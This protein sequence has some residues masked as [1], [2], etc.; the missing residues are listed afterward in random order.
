M[1]LSAN[2][3]KERSPNIYVADTLDEI[4]EILNPRLGDL[5]FL[6]VDGQFQV[7]RLLDSDLEPDGLEVLESNSC[8]FV[9]VLAGGTGTITVELFGAV[10][11]GETDDTD[12]FELAAARVP[13]GAV[14]R[15]TPG[16]TYVLHSVEVNQDVSWD[17]NGCV[18]LHRENATGHM[19]RFLAPQTGFFEG[20]VLDGNK[21]NQNARHS[22]LYTYGD[23]CQI[24]N[25]TFRNY[26]RSGII[27]GL[28]VTS[29]NVFLCR[30]R[31]GAEHGGTVGETSC[32][33][34]F[35][36]VLPNTTPCLTVD[37][38]LFSQDALP[39]VTG[40]A[41]GGILIAG[42]DSAA[43]HP[44][45]IL[46]RNTFF[47]V[48]QDLALNHIS[49]I[50]LYEDVIGATVRGNFF[51]DVLWAPCAL[52]NCSNVT[53]IDNVFECSQPISGTT[54]VL[55]YSPSTRS[56]GAGYDTCIISGNVIKGPGNGIGIAVVGPN[57]PAS[58]IIVSHNEVSNV[59]EALVLGGVNGVESPVVIA[60][61]I[62]MT[63][64]GNGTI[65]MTE[66]VGTFHIVN[67]LCEAVGANCFSAITGM[68][69]A[70]LH[71]YGNTFEADTAGLFAVVVRGVEG[72]YFH[73][74][75]YANTAVG[76]VAVNLQQ[77]A[78]ANHIIYAIFDLAHNIIRAGDTAFVYAQIDNWAVQDHPFAMATAPASGHFNAGARVRNSAPDK[79]VGWVTNL[80]GNPGTFV[81]YGL[82]NNPALVAWD[83]TLNTVGI[84]TAAPTGASVPL[85]VGKNVND[86]VQ[87]SVRNV[88]AL[89]NTSAGA[90]LMAT[91]F[92]SSGFIGAF[93]S[94]YT[95]AR[96]RDSFS[97][98][99]NS[100]AG[101]LNIMAD[102]AGQS[103]R[104]Y[105]GG[106]PETARIDGN[107]TAGETRF[108]IYDVDSGQMQRVKVGA[109][110][111]GPGGVGRA[112]YINNV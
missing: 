94:D 99:L 91:A 14:I 52:Q 13:A 88:A 2:R 104:F 73:S 76:G 69:G 9:W 6:A 3:C 16:K 68:T 19:I 84:G 55:T 101:V 78:S 34:E 49:G 59:D 111:T 21:D 74:G 98:K 71:F 85:R 102:G 87:L 105:A 11:D 89:G 28:T 96:L 38:C 100:D 37:L 50:Q 26:V 107:S 67:N 79:F 27:D 45:A 7:F 23:G 82:I 5:A 62:L 90:V 70:R 110:G 60:S 24:R 108:I 33:I 63:S 51:K 109:N 57:A 40:A 58:R 66:C 83:T 48:G 92:D 80:G 32:G 1:I 95:D 10:G 112:L 103:I 81:E 44:K 65:S 39:S 42:L 93:P 18:L 20:G 41:P 35:I 77:D 22:L 53:C 61:N 46:T 15:G 72:A 106:L 43:C 17:M 47:Q 86:L 54:P 36:P 64:G 29:L 8:E 31:N 97:L 75:E 56:Q 30:F 4:S 25:L 12:A